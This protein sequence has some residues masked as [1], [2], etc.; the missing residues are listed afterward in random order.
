MINF[1]GDYSRPDKAELEDDA[2]VIVQ[3]RGLSS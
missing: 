2:C 3:K 1:K